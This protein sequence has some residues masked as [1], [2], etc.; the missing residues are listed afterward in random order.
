MSK[1]YRE[2]ESKSGAAALSGETVLTIEATTTH[3]IEAPPEPVFVP[4]PPAI[5]E[6]VREE[7][8]QE[9][10]TVPMSEA[11]RSVREWDHLSVRSP[12]PKGGRSRSRRRSGRGSSPGGT[13]REKE[14]IIEKEKII[15]DVS[16]ARARR[17][18]H[19]HHHDDHSSQSG[20]EVI[21]E[22]TKIITEEADFDESNS[23]HVGPLALVVDRKPSRS[24]RDLKDE[25][26][27]LERERRELRRERRYDRDGA[28]GT[29]II[30]VERLRDR[31]PSPRGEVIVERRGEDILEVRKDRRGR[32]SLVAK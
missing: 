11:P 4:P 21:I 28:L 3:L 7:K 25:I 6:I 13:V 27:R 8:V 22:K 12:S 1:D 17:S 26:R 15:R 9:I 32:M 31:S 5:R 16:P 23:V 24:D 14:V 30:K 18:S 2:R 10:H 19:H 20:S 29:E